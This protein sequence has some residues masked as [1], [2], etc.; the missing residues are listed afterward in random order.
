MLFRFLSMIPQY[1]TV[2]GGG[3]GGAPPPVPALTS[4]YITHFAGVCNSHILQVNATVTVNWTQTN[5]D[6]TLHEYRIYQDNVLVSV[7]GTSSLYFKQV[8]GVVEDGCGSSW[9]SDW[10]FRV[11]IVRKSDGVVLA[12]R[13]ATGNAN[14]H[15][16]WY[17]GTCC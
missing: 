10:V 17:Y 15:H 9:Q 3:G 13:E 11:D 2:G 1:D 4:A 14:N 16:V 7:Q 6:N 5:F 12:S 8:S